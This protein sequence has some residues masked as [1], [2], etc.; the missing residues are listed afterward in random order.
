MHDL[1]I[2]NGTIVDGSGNKSFI[3]DIAVDEDRITKVGEIINIG[4]REIDAKG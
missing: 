2:R 4:K 1:V 3:A